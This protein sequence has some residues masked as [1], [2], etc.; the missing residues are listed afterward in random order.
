MAGFGFDDRTQTCTSKDV[1]CAGFYRVN[2]DLL[3]WVYLFGDLPRKAVPSAEQRAALIH[4]SFALSLVGQLEAW[5]P[6]QLLKTGLP[7]EGG[8]LP[9]AAARDVLFRLRATL[10]PDE[11]AVALLDVSSPPLPHFFTV[12]TFSCLVHITV[13]SSSCK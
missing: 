5:V 9:W 1:G 12:G 13:R 2:Y 6:L 4:D 11:E 3:T 8:L 10:G 7:V